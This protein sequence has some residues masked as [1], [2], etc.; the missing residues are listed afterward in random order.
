M[1]SKILLLKT[2]CKKYLLPQLVDIIEEYFADEIVVTSEYCQ[3]ALTG[4]IEVLK[5]LDSKPYTINLD[6][7]ELYVKAVS[8]GQ[9]EAARYLKTDCRPEDNDA[10]I[11]L[12]NC[13]DSARLTFLTQDWNL[14]RFTEEEHDFIGRD[15]HDFFRIAHTRFG[16]DYDFKEALDHAI[17]EN[18]LSI[19]HFILSN[20]LSIAPRPRNGQDGI[21]TKACLL[22]DLACWSYRL[23]KCGGFILYG[24]RLTCERCTPIKEEKS[25]GCAYIFARGE[26]KGERCGKPV[27]AGSTYCKNCIRKPPR[28]NPGRSE[29]KDAKII[30]DYDPNAIE[31]NP[32]I[33]DRTFFITKHHGFLVRSEGTSG[34]ED[35]VV[36]GKAQGNKMIPLD[37][38]DIHRALTMGMKIKDRTE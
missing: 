11:V 16:R 6:K 8:H 19:M 12:N 25:G 15:V 2:E 10:Q 30:L 9:Y 3:A 32:W 38:S 5:Y 18:A 34:D 7:D 27:V 29:N 26:K 17:N 28:A 14:G 36:Y 23:C 13:P 21:T 24:E 22:V 33:H 37:E 4:N 20:K 31:A 1:E 35:I